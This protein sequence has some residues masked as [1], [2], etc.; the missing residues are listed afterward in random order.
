MSILSST[1]LNTRFLALIFFWSLRHDDTETSSI[2]SFSNFFHFFTLAT[3][4]WSK[5]QNLNIFFPDDASLL[6]YYL[7]SLFIKLKSHD[8]YWVVCSQDLKTFHHFWIQPISSR[9]VYLQKTF[10]RNL[11]RPE[12]QSLLVK[13][14]ESVKTTTTTKRRAW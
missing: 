10:T 9:V 1:D 2:K 3:L 12:S 5:N 7:N 13:W 14:H 11:Y 4:F 6:R 8:N